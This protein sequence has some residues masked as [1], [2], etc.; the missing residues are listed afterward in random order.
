MITAAIHANTITSSLAVQYTGS[1]TW[2]FFPSDDY[3]S[4]SGFRAT[5]NAMFAVPTAA[6]RRQVT[7][8]TYNS[9]PGDLLF[10]RE[11]WPHIVLTHAG[12][13][14]LINYRQFCWGN[15][16]RQPFMFFHTMFNR[17]VHMDRTIHESNRVK[18]SPV[19]E[20]YMAKQNKVLCADGDITQ[21][22]KDMIDLITSVADVGVDA[23][24]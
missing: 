23:G 6:P 22:D 11:S 10:F 17:A 15:I 16:F 3:T 19:Q 21:V 7:A 4:E 1:K 9:R 13:N 8:F 20:K 12:P 18:P 14:I 24:Y 5:P 2:I